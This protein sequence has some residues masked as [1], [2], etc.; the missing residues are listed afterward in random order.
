MTKQPEEVDIIIVGG[1]IM[2]LGVGYE[3]LRRNRNRKILLLEKS[4][5]CAGASGRNG[6]GIRAQWSSARNIALMRESLRIASDF[7]SEHGINTWFRRGGYLFLARSDA[8]AEQLE[9]SVKL[10][11]EHG[12]KT[13][14][15]SPTDA[16]RVVPHLAENTL[17][18]ASHN[19][20][21]ALIFPWP[22]LWGY[23][24]SFEALGGTVLTQTPVD[25]ITTSQGAIT[26]VETPSG[27]IKSPLVI[28]ATGAWTVEL[29]KM[30][31]IDLPTHPHRHEIC[32]TESYKPMLEPLVADLD[33]GL[34]ISQSMRG[35]FVGGISNP[36]VPEGF[37]ARSSGAFLN[38]YATEL[39]RTMPAFAGVKVLRQWSG[40]YDITPD[41]NPIVGYCDEV[42]GFFML[43]GFMG[44]GF[45]MAPVMAKR[46]AEHIDSGAHAALFETW[47]LSRFSTGKLVSETMILG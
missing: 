4:H 44:H 40:F 22:F 20:N 28:A 9:A 19:P 37:D 31:G 42:K 17:V 14:M 21:D 34:Y 39:Q 18:A 12:L 6:G 45:M 5:L 30:V 11:R 41:A 25:D 32:S 24:R 10:Q 35:E 8:R 23:K 33:S 3:L 7:T 27:Q 46:S 47:N 38:R 36:N 1:G 29:A 26:G 13:K 43:A 2:G 15:I 16:K